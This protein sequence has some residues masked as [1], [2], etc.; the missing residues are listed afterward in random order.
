MTA[1]TKF[2][3][4]DIVLPAGAGAEAT[5]ATRFAGHRSVPGR[6]PRRP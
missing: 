5:L 2:G 4:V 6:R 1:T 3:D